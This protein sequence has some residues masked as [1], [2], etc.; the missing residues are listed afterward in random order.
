MESIKN[1][2]KSSKFKNFIL[3]V[4]SFIFVLVIFQAGIE[5]GAHKAGF[6]RKWDENYRNTFAGGPRGMMGRM[7]TG[8]GNYIVSHGTVGKIVKIDLPNIVV[9]GNDNI[10]KV[11]ITNE[12]TK[13]V[14]FREEVKVSQLK[15]NDNV[16]VIGTPNDKSEVIA[17]LI[18]IMPISM[19]YAA[20]TTPR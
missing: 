13:V 20:T 19:M 2:I 3:G 4:I 16:V 7:M 18:R 11:I 10:E 17:K 12:E 9:L 6:S 15:V 5:V 14:S 8:G 1:H